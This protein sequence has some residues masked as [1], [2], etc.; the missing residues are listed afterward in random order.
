MLS[1]NLLLATFHLL[2]VAIVL[3][4]FRDI[5]SKLEVTTQGKGL[6]LLHLGLFDYIKH[7]K[8]YTQIQTLQYLIVFVRVLTLLLCNTFHKYN[9]T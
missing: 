7:S 8:I 6:H 4:Y 3:L 1:F 5:G 9:K 2:S